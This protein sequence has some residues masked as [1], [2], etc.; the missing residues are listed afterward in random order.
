[1]KPFSNLDA[2]LKDGY[3]F[4]YDM[5]NY[6]MQEVTISIHQIGEVILT[7]GRIIACDPLIVPDTQYHLKKPVNPGHYPVIVSVA[8]FQP[9]G[10][11]RFACAV[12]RISDEA[13]VRWE[14]ALINEPDANQTDDRMAYG[15]DAGTGCFVDWDAAESIENL[16]SLEISYPEKD[17]F[18][19]FCDQLIAEMEK[20][21][22]GKHPLTA[23]WAN[24]KV[25]DT[26][27][28]IIAFSSGWGD[29]DYASFWGYGASGNLTSL[30]TDFAIFS[31]DGAA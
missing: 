23:G 18:E 24:M 16:V 27:A 4:K 22:F 14:V 15:V 31:T 26:E 20:N 21:S 17:E 3:S 29:G 28:N 11:T 1:M 12:L 7:S 5:P 19:M 30:V 10:D 6:G 8:D 13:T 25:S 9:A 2:I